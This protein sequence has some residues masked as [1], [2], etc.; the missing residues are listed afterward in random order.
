MKTGGSPYY[1]PRAR[2]LWSSLPRWRGLR[3]AFALE[4]IAPQAPVSSWSRLLL[5]LL[6]P[7]TFV[8]ARGLRLRG[9]IF[10]GLWLSLMAAYF[11]WIGTSWSSWALILASVLHSISTVMTFVAI[12]EHLPR[13]NR[14]RRSTFYGF[15]LVVLLYYVFGPLFSRRV[16]L[17]IQLFDKSY[18]INTTAP[19]RGLQRGDWIAY[20]FMNNA[21]GFDRV[22]AYP[23]E[24]IRFHP[25]AF[26]AG[27]TVY[28]RVSSSMPTAGEVTLPDATFYVWPAN[29]RVTHARDMGTAMLSQIAPV[30]EDQVIGPAYRSWFWRKLPLEPLVPLKDWTPPKSAP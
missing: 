22:L 6:V 19:V 25:D 21:T 10:F 27:G 9:W 26:E 15:L 24:T 23:G 2:G 17:P 12:L 8:L 1:P 11:I 18:L 16:V 30:R 29:A 5:W 14:I 20:R 3:R 7:G 4:R 28:Q 13:G